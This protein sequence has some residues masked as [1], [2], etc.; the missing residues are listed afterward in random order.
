MAFE[1]PKIHL[2]EAPSLLTRGDSFDFERHDNGVI[3][4]IEKAPDLDSLMAPSLHTVPEKVK[5]SN[6]FEATEPQKE[7][8][9][10]AA[11]GTQTTEEKWRAK[12]QKEHKEFVVGM[13]ASLPFL[14]FLF[15]TFPWMTPERFLIALVTL[16]A[17]YSTAS[18]KRETPKI[19]KSEQTENLV[20]GRAAMWRE[21]QAPEARDKTIQ[22]TKMIMISTILITI[23]V[24]ISRSL[25]IIPMSVFAYYIPL[26]PAIFA[27]LM[28]PL[29]IFQEAK[30]RREQQWK[31]FLKKK[32]P[33]IVKEWN[34]SVRKQEKSSAHKF[35][36]EIVGR[37]VKP[38]WVPF[39]KPKTPEA[40]KS[41]E[42]D[43]L[44]ILGMTLTWTTIALI[45]KAVLGFFGVSL[46]I[47]SL[48]AGVATFIV[49][50]YLGTRK[51]KTIVSE[52]FEE[53]VF[54][55]QWFPRRKQKF[56]EVKTT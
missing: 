10:A 6:A 4:P 51:D 40:Q 5:R 22:G 8:A 31:E 56:P 27:G 24:I 46:P 49:G 55:R 23:G 36:E 13:L 15:F 2:N 26:L 3:V 29:K 34:V 38:S 42:E 45:A 30:N 43:H 11:S 1:K 7:P 9:P 12:M 50:L 54:G 17:M 16:I 33:E 19:F 41:M 47:V 39:W 14:V 52:K 25:E 37:I 44:K 35:L 48:L 20:F 28:E 32:G 53:R 21:P 18:F